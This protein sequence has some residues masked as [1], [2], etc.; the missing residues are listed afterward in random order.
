MKGL[1]WLFLT[2]AVLGIVFA[3]LVVSRC[4]F[5]DECRANGVK[6]DTETNPLVAGYGVG[7]SAV[8][9]GGIYFIEKK[10]DEYND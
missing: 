1:K 3:F 4:D 10:E 7:F 9:I 6:I 2:L 5:E 8:F